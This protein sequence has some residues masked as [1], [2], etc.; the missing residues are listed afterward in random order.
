MGSLVFVFSMW[1][2]RSEGFSSP[3]SAL[4]MS[5]ASDPFEVSLVPFGLFK[6]PMRVFRISREGVSSTL[7][8]LSVRV[9]G[10]SFQ[11]FYGFLVLGVLSSEFSFRGFLKSSVRVVHVFFESFLCSGFPCFLM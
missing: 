8:G 11:D 9:K 1:R 7:S 2:F 5:A 10:F 6:Y 4:S 3:L